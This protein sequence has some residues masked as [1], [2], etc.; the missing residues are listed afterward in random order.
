MIVI[1]SELEYEDIGEKGQSKSLFEDRELKS[2]LQ[3]L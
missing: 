3:Q 1:T 2:E